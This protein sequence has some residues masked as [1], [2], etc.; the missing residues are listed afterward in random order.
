MW[1]NWLRA[2]VAVNRVAGAA[3]QQRGPKPAQADDR[4]TKHGQRKSRFGP[5]PKVQPASANNENTEGGRLRGDL[6]AMLWS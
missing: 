4:S 1:S 5:A 2:Q 3:L 6:E